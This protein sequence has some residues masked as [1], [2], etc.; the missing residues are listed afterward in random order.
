MPWSGFRSKTDGRTSTHRRRLLNGKSLAIPAAKLAEEL[1]NVRM[2]NTVMVGAY[3]AKTGI[4]SPEAIE[5]TLPLAI[6]RRYLV[7]ANKKALA[8]GIEFAQSG[9]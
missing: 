3:I 6:K 4:I 5:Q 9:E 8:R 1:G 2:A 7:E